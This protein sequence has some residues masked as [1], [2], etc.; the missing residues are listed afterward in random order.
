MEEHHYWLGCK[1]DK[2]TPFKSVFFFRSLLNRIFFL[3]K[4]SYQ[5]MKRLQESPHLVTYS[6]M[7]SLWSQEWQGKKQT[8]KKKVTDHGKKFT[9]IHTYSKSNTIRTTGM[10]L[11]KQ[12]C[13]W[14]RVRVVHE[15]LALYPGQ[16]GNTFWNSCLLRLSYCLLRALF[17]KLI[18]PKSCSSIRFG[19]FSS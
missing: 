1:L 7:D 2:Q 13:S 3:N 5:V 17:A 18:S 14:V 15:V 12:K 19:S 11:S 16:T 8:V 4:S 10:Y 6:Y 9:L